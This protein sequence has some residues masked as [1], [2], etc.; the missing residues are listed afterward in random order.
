M[1][2]SLFGTFIPY[3]GLCIAT[4]VVC[5]FSLGVFLCKKS[6]LC[7][8]NF[9][10]IC[11]YLYAFGFAGAKLLYIIVSFKDIDF[12][13][14]FHDTKSFNNFLGSGFV[15]YG[16]IIGGFLAILFVQKFHKIQMDS[17]IRILAPCTSL[18]HAFGRI[19]CSL[20]GCCYGKETSCRVFYRYTDSIV[21]P[22]GVNL[23]PVQGVESLCL[24]CLT[25][26]LVRLYLKNHACRVHLVYI[27][28]YAVIR[29]VLEIFRGDA[30]RGG[31]LFLSTS[32]IISIVLLAGLSLFHR[33]HIKTFHLA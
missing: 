14:V 6:G 18:G 15:F 3:Y 28:T 19:G 26:I 24:F 4:G 8:D 17:Y 2:F 7:T 21:A 33:K 16:G 30:G 31:F 23:F 13:A 22:N 27:V 1:E 25:L 11:A 10:L 29:F 20:A 12:Q 9:L 5:A 32:Q